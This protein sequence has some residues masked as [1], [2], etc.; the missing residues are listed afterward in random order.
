MVNPPKDLNL[1]RFDLVLAESFRR[2]V[3]DCGG[4]IW[5]ANGVISW[6]GSLKQASPAHANGMLRL[7]RLMSGR[8]VMGIAAG[9]FRA[10][11]HGFTVLV[12]ADDRALQGEI[13]NAGRQ[14]KAE[15]AALVLTD[16]SVESSKGSRPVEVLRV[17]G[18][19]DMLNFCATISA[20]SGSDQATQRFVNHA[21]RRVQALLGPT[22]GAFLAYHDGHAVACALG[23][24]IDGVAWIGWIGSKPDH[25]REGLAT[26]VTRSAIQSAY[27]QGATR[28]AVLSP[29]PAIPFFRAMGFEEVGRYREYVFPPPA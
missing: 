12:R 5:E 1:N 29:G 17:K 19:S 18:P 11:G 24:L 28:A 3:R 13:E 22:R 23:S 8:E 2:T 6:A 10:R 16:P 25:R 27:E 4:E 20:A 7:N 15:H 14:M 9:F 26:A 21:L